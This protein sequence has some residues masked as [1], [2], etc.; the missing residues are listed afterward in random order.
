MFGTRQKQEGENS[1]G[2][3]RDRHRRGADRKKGNAEG[4]SNVCASCS[5]VDDSLKKIQIR[6]DVHSNTHL[7][8]A[9]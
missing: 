4:E 8:V 7:I 3:L 2:L 6:H 5:A 9:M 1:E